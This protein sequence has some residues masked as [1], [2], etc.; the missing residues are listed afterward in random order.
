M[1][2][3][4]AEQPTERQIPLWP[5]EPPDSAPGDS[6]RPWLEPYPVETDKPR[7]AV[8]ICPGGG[9]GGR[10][11]HEGAPIAKRLNEAGLHGFVV[12]YRVAP[13]RHP[14]PLMDALRAL[15]IV[16]HRAAEWNVDPHRL[17]ILG[18]SAG[19][20]LAG[21]AGVHY[22]VLPVRADDEIDR[23]S[24]RPDALV[25]CY[26]VLSSG[27]LGHR[28]SFHNLLGD[29]QSPELLHLMSLETQ[30]TK[31]TPPTF[32]WHT[33]ADAGVPVENSLLFAQALRD[34]GV[35]FEMHLY[36]DGQHGLGLAPGDPHVATWAE[37][38]GQWL[39]GRGW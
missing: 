6:F 28:G 16:R 37:L 38:C 22:N 19:G 7:G 15:R 30:V 25:L 8:L 13:N 17:A 35:S 23:E 27:K 32:L 11:P 29:D 12:Q 4:S 26:A 21:S 1:A 3:R 9:Y 5:G 20:H 33:V 14:A 10:A 2:E 18:F 36:P 31:E 34:H 24:S 39:Q